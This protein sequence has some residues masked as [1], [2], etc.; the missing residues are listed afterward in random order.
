MGT[1]KH[2]HTDTQMNT[3]THTHEHTQRHTTD[4]YTHGDTHTHTDTRVCVIQVF[5]THILFSHP[6][7]LLKPNIS[8]SGQL[9]FYA[10]AN[11]L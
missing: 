1:H 9:P 8:G 2:I 11:P 5:V 4:T 10:A 3:D 6:L 7:V